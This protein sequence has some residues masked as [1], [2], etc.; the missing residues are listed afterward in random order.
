MALG[1]IDQ[2]LQKKS[3]ENDSTTP[4]PVEKSVMGDILFERDL[5]AESKR[6]MSYIFG[7]TLF[8]KYMDAIKAS[9]DIHNPELAREAVVAAI[10]KE[11]DPRYAE[12]MAL[13]HNDI[14]LKYAKAGKNFAIDVDSE[15]WSKR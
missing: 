3:Y 4:P 15:V 1:I 12:C 2:K 10:K 13:L 14:Y 8:E 7:R 9:S 5:Q 6:L 11:D